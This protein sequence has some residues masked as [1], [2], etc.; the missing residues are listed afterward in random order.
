MG[1]KSKNLGQE[2]EDKVR[3]FF[4]SVGW[5][6]LS[7]GFDIDCI[8]PDR[9]KHLAAKSGRTTHGIDFAFSYV[10][11]IVIDRRQNVLISV[12]NSATEKTSTNKSLMQSDLQDLSTAL[13]CFRSS[14]QRAQMNEAG[15]GATRSEDLGILIRLNKD[16]DSQQSYLGEDTARERIEIE[17]SCP[18]YVIENARFDHIERVMK[19]VATYFEGLDHSFALPK[20][21]LNF[22]ADHRRTNSSL[23][24]AQSLTGG[25]IAIRLE[26]QQGGSGASLAVYTEE[27][28][29][30]ERFRRL[31]SLSLE[32]SSN[33]V[34]VTII[35]P[36]FRMQTHGEIVG[37]AVAGLA[38]KDYA[39]KV[40]CASLEERS[41]L[42]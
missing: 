8:L 15:S 14:S 12:K 31:A 9:H 30:I 20:S 18:L 13:R 25:P 17:G 23:L 33:W 24:P 2:G 28:F 6:A 34:Q 21:S 3:S 40:H 7:P 5:P 32:L 29:E 22:S 10:C 39:A 42:K 19:H 26:S 36:D 38:Q 37:Q 4:K 11:P 27:P 41:R 16:K 1:E 35:F